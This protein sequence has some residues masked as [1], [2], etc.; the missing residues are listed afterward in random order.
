[1]TDEIQSPRSLP[2]DVVSI[3]EANTP[4][5]LVGGQAVNAWALYYA[6]ST[7]EYAPF[8]SRDVDVLGDRETLL[9]IANATGSKPQF[10]PMRPPTNEVGVVFIETGGTS[11]PVEVLSHVNGIDNDS[12]CNPAYTIAVGNRSVCVR[13]PSPVALLQAK[14]ANVQDLNQTDRQDERHVR[15][16]MA[17]MPDYLA[18][19]ATAAK[20]GRIKER[21]VVQMLERLLKTITA[22]RVQ[23]LLLS[24]GIQ[25]HDAFSSL[26]PFSSELP[27]IHLFLNNRLPRALPSQEKENP[28]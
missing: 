15:I 4:L 7:R 13:V 19:L 22:K 8:V 12:L 2:P 1:M 24:L 10:F 21:E 20:A 27:K 18:D 6:E 28:G 5:F 25:A 9:K 16:L 23:H 17:L 3:L 14:I 11:F 26:K